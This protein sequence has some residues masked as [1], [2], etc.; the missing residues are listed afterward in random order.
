[1]SRLNFLIIPAC[2]AAVVAF[3]GPAFA[4]GTQRTREAA[5]RAENDRWVEA[6]KRGD[7]DA[8]AVLY[9]PDAKLLPEGSEAVTGP[10]A[11]VAYFKSISAG[12]PPTTLRFSN[13]EFYGND[14]VMT[15]VTDTEVRD[16]GGRL[17]SRGK[18]ILIFV[19]KDGVWKLHRDIWTRNGPLKTDDR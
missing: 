14:Q 15:E 10:A 3:S 7:M 11:I 12:A 18:Q 2:M 6:H 5:I 9:T 17:K 16:A 1:M 4:T 19:K 13:Y 8:L